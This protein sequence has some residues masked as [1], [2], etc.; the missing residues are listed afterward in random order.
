MSGHK[1][2]AIDVSPEMQSIVQDAV[3][4]GEYVSVSDVFEAALND[5]QARRNGHD[6]TDTKLGELW[7]AGIASGHPT[8]GEKA[9]SRTRAELVTRLAASRS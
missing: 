2:V 6:L 5:W 8:D 9:F 3:D 4:S 7:D 1:V